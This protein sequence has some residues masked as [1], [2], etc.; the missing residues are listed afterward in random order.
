MDIKS[1]DAIVRVKRGEHN[2]QLED[3]LAKIAEVGDEL[4]FGE[5]RSKLLH[6]S[7]FD[8]KTITQLDMMQG[9]IVG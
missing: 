9:A 2:I 4:C 5:W 1:E 3:V 8:M 6:R 7:S